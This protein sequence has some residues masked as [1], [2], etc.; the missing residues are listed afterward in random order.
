MEGKQRDTAT[1]DHQ[2]FNIKVTDSAGVGI[3]LIILQ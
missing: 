3:T 1:L 2:A